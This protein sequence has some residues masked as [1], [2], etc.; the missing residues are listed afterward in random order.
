M[1][2]S[3]VS[4]CFGVAYSLALAVAPVLIVC[5]IRHP[6]IRHQKSFISR[7][8]Y[9]GVEVQDHTGHGPSKL[10]VQSTG[11]HDANGM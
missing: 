11:F 7:S 5:T 9:D 2:G 8:C 6:T 3:R 4:K 1:E 10:G